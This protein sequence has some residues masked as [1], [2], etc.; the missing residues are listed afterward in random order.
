SGKGYADIVRLVGARTPQGQR[1]AAYLTGEV[2]K[3]LGSVKLKATVTD[4]SKHYYSIYQTMQ[5]QD[6][7]FNESYDLLGIRVLVDSVRDC[8]AV[9]GALHARWSPIP[10]RFKD[11]I[12]MPK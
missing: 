10:G 8:Y 9:L 7:E 3:E 12:A 1:V 6:K 11:Y 2:D 4:R 5:E